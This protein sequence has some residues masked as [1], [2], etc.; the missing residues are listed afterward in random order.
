MGCMRTESVKCKHLHSAVTSF[1]SYPD[2]DTY[3]AMKALS[4]DIQAV[5]TRHLYIYLC[6]R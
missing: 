5:V 3:I 1:Q 4:H 6:H 2:N